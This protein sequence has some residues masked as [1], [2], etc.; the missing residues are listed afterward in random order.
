MISLINSVFITLLF[1]VWVWQLKQEIEGMR[2]LAHGGAP[3]M[4]VQ[5]AVP[6]HRGPV[7]RTDSALFDQSGKARTKEGVPTWT[8]M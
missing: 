1:S 5:H 4:D 8:I 6:S 2:E 3:G 7:R